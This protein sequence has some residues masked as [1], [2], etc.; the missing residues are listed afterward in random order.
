MLMQI[1]R[2]VGGQLVQGWGGFGRER[3]YIRCTAAVASV[4]FYRGGSGPILPHHHM[5][6]GTAE[7]EGADSRKTFLGR[8]PGHGLSRN[9]HRHPIPSNPRI[10]SVKM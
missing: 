10:G 3:Q 4:G 7:A 2:I 6:I 9:D 8:G 1:L 5:R